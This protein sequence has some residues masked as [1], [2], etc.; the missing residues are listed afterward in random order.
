MSSLSEIALLTTSTS[1][2]LY[3]IIGLID[4]DVLISYYKV[5]T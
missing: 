2:C 4:I 5:K 3:L 1:D